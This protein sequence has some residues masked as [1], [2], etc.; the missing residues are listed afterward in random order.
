[1][2]RVGIALTVYGI[3]FEPRP[4]SAFGEA[5]E[6]RPHNPLT[7]VPTLVL[8]NGEVLIEGHLMLDYLDGLVPADRRMFPV[9][10][11]TRH[12]AVKASA[13]ATGLGDK[14]VSLFCEKRLHEKVSDVWAAAAARRSR[15]CSP[16]WRP[17]EPAGRHPIGSASAL[18]MPTSRLPPYRVSW[19]GASGA[20]R[21]RGANG[22]PGGLPGDFTG[23]YRT[24]LRALMPTADLPT[25]IEVSRGA[26]HGIET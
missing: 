13:L 16:C 1:M 24:G 5:D 11:P 9:S 4:W 15:P 18:V 7:R 23:L 14:T 21:S 25:S 12:Q 3:S 19:R 17:S 22:S 10:E 2:R 6:I 26:R 8:D 20:K